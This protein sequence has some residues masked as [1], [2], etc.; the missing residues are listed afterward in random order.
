MIVD[1]GLCHKPRVKYPWLLNVV[2]KT[3]AAD[4]IVD[5]VRRNYLEITVPSDLF[6]KS[7]VRCPYK[8]AST[9]CNDV[10]N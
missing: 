4:Q 7:R 1:T 8:L 2:K 3:D 6:Y 9:V 10:H 5:A